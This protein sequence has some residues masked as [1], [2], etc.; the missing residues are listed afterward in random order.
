MVGVFCLALTALVV[1]VSGAVGYH[2]GVT[3]PFVPS[4]PDEPHSHS[5]RITFRVSLF[6]GGTGALWWFQQGL[7]SSPVSLGELQQESPEPLLREIKG[8]WQTV[9][10]ERDLLLLCSTPFILVMR[11]GDPGN[12]RER[13]SWRPT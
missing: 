11:H 2:Q 7:Q 13:P 9:P 6:L 1:P 3:H 10:A 4:G 12:D 5:V 8:E